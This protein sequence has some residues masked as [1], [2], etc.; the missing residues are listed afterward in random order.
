MHEPLPVSIASNAVA[1]AGKATAVLHANAG[2]DAGDYI[3]AHSIAASMST[4]PSALGVSAREVEQVDTSEGNEEAANKRERVYRV[5][6]V[7]AAEESKGGAQRSRSKG[8]VVERV[9]TANGWV[10]RGS[11][12]GRL[13]G[14][15]PAFSF[16]EKLTCSWGTG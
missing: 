3:S 15:G 5:G 2:L 6:C 7:E 14:H 10:S 13:P 11:K 4:Q 12:G 1:V 8:N 9:D 16:L